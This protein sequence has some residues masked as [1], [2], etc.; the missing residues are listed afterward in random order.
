MPFEDPTLAAAA[1]LE[2]RLS[3]FQEDDILKA[4]SF[5]YP[6]NSI[7]FPVLNGPVVLRYPTVLDSVE[8]ARKS[9]LLGG[10]YVAEVLATAMVLTDK[11]PSSWYTRR[12]KDDPLVLR[13]EQLPD[14]EELT[15]LFIAFNAWRD[16]FR[17][18][19][20]GK[21]VEGANP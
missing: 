9:R 14:V 21:P 11:A 10:T 15:N 17:R 3:D 16:S 20:P 12:Q 2:P 19:G 8:I 1:G 6:F 5:T 7:A 13:V 4:P 18:T